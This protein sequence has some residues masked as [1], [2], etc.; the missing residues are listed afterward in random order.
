MSGTPISSAQVLG[1][2]LTQ[3]AAGR[4]ARKRV[5]GVI[6]LGSVTPAAYTAGEL[7]LLNTLALQTATAIENARLFERLRERNRVLS[8]RAVDRHGR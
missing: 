1:D 4:M 7:K 5:I 2:C 3:C 6:A 8:A